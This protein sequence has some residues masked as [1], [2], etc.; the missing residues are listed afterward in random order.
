MYQNVIY[1]S[2][3]LDSLMCHLENDNC[4]IVMGYKYSKNEYN[5]RYDY[6]AYYE[7]CLVL[8]LGALAT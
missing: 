1:F 8:T 4:A 3:V 6:W 7:V 5:Y 2:E